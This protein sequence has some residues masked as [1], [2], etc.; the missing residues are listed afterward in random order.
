MSEL[1]IIMNDFWI[2]VYILVHVVVPPAACFMLRKRKSYSWIKC[3]GCNF[4]LMYV[5]IVLSSVAYGVVL[6]V[7][8]NSF[9]HWGLIPDDSELT[10]EQRRTLELYLN[11]TGRSLA[12]ITGLFFSF[13]HTLGL[14]LLILIG[15]SVK[16][17]VRLRNRKV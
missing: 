4:I 3:I 11:D 12:P 8:V 6:E 9:S 5:L 10:E 1:W 7:K 14:A 2:I 13:A 16:K 15:V 17:V